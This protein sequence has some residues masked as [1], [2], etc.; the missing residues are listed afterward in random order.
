MHNYPMI[1]FDLFS[2]GV[3]YDL[4]MFCSIYSYAELA[5][6]SCA[7]PL[8][9]IASHTAAP[10]L[11]NTSPVCSQNTLSLQKLDCVQNLIFVPLNLS[12]VSIFFHQGFRFTLKL[13]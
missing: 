1:S 3:K 4:D 2:S 6:L 5:L 12:N 10:P 7:Q 9:P 8:S 11:N 13:I